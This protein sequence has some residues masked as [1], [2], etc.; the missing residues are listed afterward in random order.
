V[1]QATLIQTQQSKMLPTC[2]RESN[3]SLEV[4]CFGLLGSVS[5]L[6]L[7]KDA[8]IMGGELNVAQGIDEISRMIGELTAYIHEHRHGVAN[9]SMKMDGLNLDISKQM[10]ALE[11]KLT[12]RMDAAHAQ[13]E[14]RIKKLEEERI[15]ND[16]TRGLLTSL[17]NSRATG[18][19]V[20]GVSA[21][22]A[23]VNG[24]LHLPR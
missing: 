7:L 13:M 12:A 20:A 19:I 23:W 14:E 8:N 9:L 11:T 21:V 22:I 17:V 3:C 1:N 6:R 10:N 24:W 18:W 2:L 15:R 5:M 16:T 4:E